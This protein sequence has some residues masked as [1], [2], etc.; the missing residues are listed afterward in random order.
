[1]SRCFDIEGNNLAFEPLEK[2]ANRGKKGKG[3]RSSQC[4]NGKRNESKRGSVMGRFCDENGLPVDDD[5]YYEKPNIGLMSKEEHEQL[6]VN[7]KSIDL[8]EGITMSFSNNFSG[9]LASYLHD[10]QDFLEKKNEKYGD[11][12]LNPIRIFSSANRLEQL[13][14]RI[15]DKLNRVKQGSLSEDEDTIKDL[16]GYLVLYD[17]AIQEDRKKEK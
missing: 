15:D 4:E 5:Y 10:M 1:M 16:I 8:G 13:R 3:K 17:I 14:V 2:N 6:C 12:A 9:V 7:M 11:S